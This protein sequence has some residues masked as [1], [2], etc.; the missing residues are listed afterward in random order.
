[1]PFHDLPPDV[2]R[3]V[4]EGRAISRRREMLMAHCQLQSA[5]REREDGSIG[6]VPQCGQ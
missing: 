3:E 5:G 4:S 2:N 1:L 6:G